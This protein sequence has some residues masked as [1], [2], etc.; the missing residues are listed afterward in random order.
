MSDPS[1]GPTPVNNPTPGASEAP[2]VLQQT[3]QVL[4]AGQIAALPT[5][6]GYVL[7]AHATHPEAVL[8]LAGLAERL[9]TTEGPPR[10]YLAV[11]GASDVR[12]LLPNLSP[13]GLRLARRFW[14]GPL[15]LR[16]P[17]AASSLSGRL[18]PT[19]LPALCPDGAL[20]LR[21]P[22]SDLLMHLLPVLG[23]PV[24]LLD[25]PEPA[26]GTAE[27]DCTGAA[28][29]KALGLEVD[30]VIDEGPRPPR[31]PSTVVEVHGDQWN[32]VHEGVLLRATMERY[33]GCVILFVCTG[34]TCRSPLAEAL[35]KRRLA[36]RLGCGIEELPARG[37][38]VLSAGLAAMMGQ[39][40]ADEAIVV[41]REYGVDL[42]NHASRLLTEDLAAQADFLVGMTRNHLLGMEDGCPRLGSLPRLARPDGLDVADPIGQS[43]AVYQE[44]ARQLWQA[45]EPLVEEALAGP[46]PAPAVAP[47]EG[48]P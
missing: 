10:L 47:R 9:T 31:Q 16:V 15:L 26:A 17:D 38:F 2:D 29:L 14:P 36:D 41:A 27:A 23:S 13:V 40:A 34:N 44:C 43:R 45:L 3:W 20:D 48:V 11:R 30:L 25:L 19:L 39:R 6:T 24:V 18:A 21:L 4:T 42:A 28:R 1:T 32:V 22:G 7:A 12:D 35:C 37:F 5:E 46:G 8:R 33:L